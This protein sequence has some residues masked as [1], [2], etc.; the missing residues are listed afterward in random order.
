MRK[1][2]TAEAGV[3]AHMPRDGSS[4]SAAHHISIGDDMQ[5][6]QQQK[7]KHFECDI[8]VSLADGVCLRRIDTG[9][10]VFMRRL[11]NGRLVKAEM[12]ARI[13]KQI[14]QFN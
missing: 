1:T 12:P 11:R 4:P 14:A 5:T 2:E 8:A 13:K 10:W 3:G 9:A 6:Q 7:P